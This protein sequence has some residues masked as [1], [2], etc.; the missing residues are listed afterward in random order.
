MTK[1]ERFIE[2]FKF[3][4]VIILAV[5]VMLLV[6]PWI[7]YVATGVELFLLINSGVVISVVGFAAFAVWIVSI[8]VNNVCTLL[9]RRVIHL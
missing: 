1:L 7:T 3:V 4:V 6:I 8:T 2:Q 9:K 5:A